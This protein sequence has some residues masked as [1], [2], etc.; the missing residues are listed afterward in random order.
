[1]MTSYQGENQLKELM[2]DINIICMMENNN[3]KYFNNTFS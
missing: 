3:K 2:A 1:M